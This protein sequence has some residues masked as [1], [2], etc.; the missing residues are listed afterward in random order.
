LR[1]NKAGTSNGSAGADESF[2]DLENDLDH[3][4]VL[5]E[6]F[7]Y[8]QFFNVKLKEGVEGDSLF[9]KVD[10]SLTRDFEPSIKI[11]D[12]V[13]FLGRFKIRPLRQWQNRRLLNVKKQA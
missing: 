8:V 12:A 4:A 3:F 5:D 11:N 1:K 7:T 9:A 6:Q 13:I 2:I 10:S